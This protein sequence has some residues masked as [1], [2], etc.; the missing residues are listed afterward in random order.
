MFLGVNPEAAALTNM[1]AL[2][3]HGNKDIR[4]DDIPIPDLKPG[5]VRVK[6]A[7]AGICGSGKNIEFRLLPEARADYYM[8]PP[9][10]LNWSFKCSD[11]GAC[12]DRRDIAHRLW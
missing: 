8:R 10:V 1:R 2:R 6:N 7:Y 11:E 3:F 4:I 12:S 9:R 5:Y